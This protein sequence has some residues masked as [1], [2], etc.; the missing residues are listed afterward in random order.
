E[1]SFNSSVSFMDNVNN[2]I[3]RSLKYRERHLLFVKLLEEEKRLHTP[4]VQQILININKETISY[5]SGKLRIAIERGEIRD[6]NVEVI[7]YVMLKAY[8]ALIF[9]WQHMH[10]EAL[11]E[12]EIV[13]V[14]QE[15]IIRGL[16]V[17]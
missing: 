8:I 13:S 10:D 3:M 7:A 9:D 6:C 1:Q 16:T 12:E 5:I 17:K 15:T 2:S 14:I 4:E 11:R